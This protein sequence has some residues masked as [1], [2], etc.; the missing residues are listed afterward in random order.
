MGRFSF[1]QTVRAIVIVQKLTEFRIICN[2][3]IAILLKA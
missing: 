2:S 3:Q 1:I